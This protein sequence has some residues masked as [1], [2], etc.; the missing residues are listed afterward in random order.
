MLDE[1]T[2]NTQVIICDSCQVNEVT[3]DE[4]YPL[5][6]DCYEQENPKGD[7]LPLDFNK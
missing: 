4:K 7:L 5:C 2:G 1:T 3:D 6:D